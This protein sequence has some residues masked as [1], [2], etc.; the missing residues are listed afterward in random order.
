MGRAVRSTSMVWN[1]RRL[2]AAHGGDL[3]AEVCQIGIIEWGIANGEVE[4]DHA[5]GPNI[6]LV[7]VVDPLGEDLWCDECWRAVE[8][9]EE[10]VAGGRGD[11]GVETEIGD[12]EVTLVIE[13]VLELK[14]AVKDA[15]G[16]AEGDGL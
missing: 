12:L 15:A 6:D 7:T 13:E 1:L 9:L 2:E 3:A 14:V 16:M 10:E 8:G 4:E 5:T 11:D